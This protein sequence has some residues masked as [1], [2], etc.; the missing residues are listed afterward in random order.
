MRLYHATYRACIDSIKQRGLT[1]DKTNIKAWPDCSSDYIYLTTDADAAI[2]FAEG[3]EAVPEGWINEIILLVVDMKALDW[4]KF[5]LDDNLL[6]D[7]RLNTYQY[8]GD[9]PASAVRQSSFL[10]HRQ[11]CCL[12]CR[13]EFLNKC[14]KLKENE[15]LREIWDAMEKRIMPFMEGSVKEHQ[16]KRELSCPNFQSKYIQYPLEISGI[17]YPEK[18]VE[19]HHGREVG[20]MVVIRPS[21][22]D[23]TYLGIYLGDLPVGIYATH[24]EE[25]GKL[26]LKHDRNP[27][28]FVP[29]LDRIV[30]GMESWWHM[31]ETV[32]DMSDISNHDI[33]NQWYVKALWQIKD[34]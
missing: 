15:T 29:D 9:I 17:E 10:E 34:G 24:N 16:V 19:V 4:A 32:E 3:S 26:S 12:N 13:H 8:A 2:A 21:D 18:T 6:D 30:Y 5:S 1:R 25:S 33:N 7:T 23:K 11:Q 28:I 27:A 22:A 20:K 14:P 31:I